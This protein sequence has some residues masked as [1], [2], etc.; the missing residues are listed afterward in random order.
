MRTAVLKHTD[1]LQVLPFV[2]R[3]C[4]ISCVGLE[5]V[6]EIYFKYDP[7]EVSVSITQPVAIK[8]DIRNDNMARELA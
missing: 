1:V 2:L 4:R 7:I 8:S 5:T 3:V 6:D